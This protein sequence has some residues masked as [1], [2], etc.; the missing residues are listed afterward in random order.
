V[1]GYD[2]RNPQGASPVFTNCASRKE[3]ESS[4]LVG[5]H[6]RFPFTSVVVMQKTQ[7]RIVAGS[8]RGRKLTV[9]V[10]AG[11]RPTPQRVREALFSILGNA[12]PGRPF[13]DVFAGTGVVGLEAL[14]RGADGVTF[15]E[16][17]HRLAND[18][19]ANLK[20]FGVARDA[21]LVRTDVYRW[22]ERWRPPAGPANVFVSPPFPDLEAR[23][24]DFERLLT[25]LQAKLPYGSVLVVQAEDAFDPAALPDAAR[26]EGRTY[27]RN[28]LF[29]WEPAGASPEPVAQDSSSD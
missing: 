4:F 25:S 17:D 22:A 13:V 15:V 8:L 21:H 20:A 28:V 14:S 1:Q 2:T 10:H 9:V 24:E 5:V 12:V 3:I 27:G 6:R 26:W 7:I 23:P 18:L 29:F 16:R 11:L 19:D